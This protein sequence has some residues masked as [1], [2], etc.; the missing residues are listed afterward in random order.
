MNRKDLQVIAEKRIKEAKILFDNDC[1]EGAYYLAGYSI[2]CA[3]KACV[4]KQIKRHDFP[5]KKF[6]NDSYT[7]KLNDL[8]GLAGI[9]EKQKNKATQDQDFALNW[10]VV[11]DWSERD[12]YTKKVT[13]QKASDIIEAIT[14]NQK[15]IFQWLK[16]LW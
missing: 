9:R 1:F 10:A 12:R 16:T 6:I 14:N 13:K 4:A 11:K 5:D 3:L 7:H 15:G 8:L 2:E